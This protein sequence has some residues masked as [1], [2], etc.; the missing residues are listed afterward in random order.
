MRSG[1]DGVQPSAVTHQ[2]RRG[3]VDRQGLL[4]HKGAMDCARI[5]EEF[6]PIPIRRGK[7]RL[8]YA[9]FRL[10]TFLDLQLLTCVRFLEPRLALMR[11][12][13]LDVG[14]GEMPFRELL[15]QD[16]DYTGIDVPQAD[17]FGMTRQAEI[18]AF[19]GVHIP[20]P[21]ASF[22]HILCTE[23]L[24]HVEEPEALI[25]EMYRVLRSGGTLVATVPFSARVHHAP[26]DYH[27][28]TGYR[29]AKL[30]AD[31]TGLEIRERGDD[32]AV[33]ANKLIVVCI[34]LVRPSSSL[35]W[36]LPLFLLVGP[37]AA[38][39]LFVAHL[40]LWLGWGSKADPLGYG[41]FAK[42]V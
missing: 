18:V 5:S 17:D 1:Q 38:L 25:A 14:C 6:K 22:D 24:E 8:G 28:F 27:R 10:R 40:S 35:L 37:A 23:V 36:R 39:S 15:P 42:K 21:D 41:I 9:A 16:V 13:V 7:G 33:I 32:L 31:F 4:G 2:F 26:Y 12:A 30:F 20:F 3:R 29:L 34:R 11:G 19:D